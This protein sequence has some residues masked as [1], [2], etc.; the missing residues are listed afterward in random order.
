MTFKIVVNGTDRSVDVD[1]DTPLLW[2]LRG[3]TGNDRYKVRL[4]R[5]LVRRLYR[6]RRRN[7]YPFLCDP[8]R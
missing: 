8:Y 2:V 4:R 5:G 3:R 1:G 6:A 7:P